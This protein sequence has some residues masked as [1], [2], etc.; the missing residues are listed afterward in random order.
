MLNE[1]FTVWE[2]DYMKAF[3]KRLSADQQVKSVYI[4]KRVVSPLVMFNLHEK[5]IE[6]YDSFGMFLEN[7]LDRKILTLNELNEQW[8]TIYQHDWPKVRLIVSLYL[9]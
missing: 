7:L 6:S 5:P 2:H 1:F 4:F 3:V 9:T 8:V